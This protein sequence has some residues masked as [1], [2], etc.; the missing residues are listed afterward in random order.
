VLVIMQKEAPNLFQDYQL[1][2]L[3]DGTHEA[4]TPHRKV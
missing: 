2:P 3:P 4:V 1:V